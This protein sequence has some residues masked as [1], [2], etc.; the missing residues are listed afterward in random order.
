MERMGSLLILSVIYTITIATILNVVTV[1]GLG[2]KMLCKNHL[3]FTFSF[4]SVRI[5]PGKIDR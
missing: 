3:N 5:R 1:T 4:H 2:L